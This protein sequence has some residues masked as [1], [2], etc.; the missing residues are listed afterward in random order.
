VKRLILLVLAVAALSFAA[1]GSVRA[2]DA[3]PLTTTIQCADGTSWVLDQDQVAWFGDA[4]CDGGYSVVAPQDPASADD[5]AAPFG[6]GLGDF[7]LSS[8]M[9]PDTSSYVTEVTCPNG[10][11]WAVASGDDFVCPAA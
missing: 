4:F 7:S 9:A 1:A 8:S 2:D 10:Q 5:A 3:I 11:V 6:I